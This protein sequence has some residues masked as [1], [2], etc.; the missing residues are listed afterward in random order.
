MINITKACPYCL[1]L[2]MSTFIAGHFCAISLMLKKCFSFSMGNL[3]INNN[4]GK[5]T[6]Q[7]SSHKVGGGGS[8]LGFFT[9][10]DMW[11]MMKLSKYTKLLNSQLI[12]SSWLYLYDVLPCLLPSDMQESKAEHM[13]RYPNHNI[14]DL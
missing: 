2:Q 4:S 11:K 7:S 10:N 9:L 14:I 5:N 1:Q 13:Q 8:F 3:L 12:M 6:L